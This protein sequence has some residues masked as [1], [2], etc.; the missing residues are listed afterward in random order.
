MVTI[1][2][3]GVYVLTG[4]LT[5]GRV[6]VNAL[7]A[8][9]TLVLQDADI[10][11]SDSSIAISGGQ[12]QRLCIARAMLRHPAILILDDSTSAVDTATDA[13]IRQSQLV[14]ADERFRL[15]GDLTVFLCRQ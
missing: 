9:V 15:L 14:G 8:D 1:T 10:T 5:D 2:D 6:L 11:C 3:G 13:K 7:D 4:T 12:K